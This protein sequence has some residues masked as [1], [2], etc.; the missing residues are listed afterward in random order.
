MREY[1]RRGQNEVD[2]PS[3]RKRRRSRSEPPILL[4]HG[5]ATSF[6]PNIENGT[7][8]DIIE[9]VCQSFQTDKFVKTHCYTCDLSYFDS[10]MSNSLLCKR[11]H[12]SI[13]RND[14]SEDSKTNGFD[15]GDIPPELSG[16]SLLERDPDFSYPSAL[17]NC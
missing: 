17:Y 7:I 1:R 16:L 3:H 8:N 12:E 6:P 9:D 2:N 13:M 10:D 15:F 14:I 5:P 4:S 11:C